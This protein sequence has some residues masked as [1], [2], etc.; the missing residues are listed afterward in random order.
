MISQDFLAELPENKSLPQGPSG[1]RWLARGSGDLC[2]PTVRD[3]LSYTNMALVGGLSSLGRLVV[4]VAFLEQR[5]GVG[6]GGHLGRKIEKDRGRWWSARQNHCGRG[7]TSPLATSTSHTATCPLPFPMPHLYFTLFCVSSSGPWISNVQE[8]CPLVEG[9]AGSSQS[10]S[11]EC[12]F[13][14][15]CDWEGV[16]ILDTLIS[17]WANTQHLWYV[18]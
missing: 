14:F 5:S 9:R 1:N 7:L 8:P 3:S 4:T 10:L 2:W 18:P 6:S 11:K 13:S 17:A 15:Q 12:H 16:E